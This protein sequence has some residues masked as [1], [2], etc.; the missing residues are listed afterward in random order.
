MQ[1][2]YDDASKQ[3]KSIKYLLF[4]SH[5]LTTPEKL[6]ELKMTKLIYCTLTHTFPETSKDRFGS[7]QCG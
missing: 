4:L 7:I 1:S 3:M 5:G 2:E 6:E